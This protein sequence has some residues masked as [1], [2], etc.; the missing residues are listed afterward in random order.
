[1]ENIDLAYI[2][3][4]CKIIRERCNDIERKNIFSNT[5]E[6]ISLVLYDWEVEHG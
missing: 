4:I 3:E 2:W 6:K 1:L 5:S